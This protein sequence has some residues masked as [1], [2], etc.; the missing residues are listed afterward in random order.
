MLLV[1][2]VGGLNFKR[3]GKCN[4]TSQSWLPQDSIILITWM[5]VDKTSRLTL[6]AQI[7]QWRETGEDG[8]HK[9]NYTCTHA[10]PGET[11]GDVGSPSKSS[12][13]FWDP[14]ASSTTY[15]NE[16]TS[17][18]LNSSSNSCFLPTFLMI[19]RYYIIA[20]AWNWATERP[21]AAGRT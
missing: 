11:L 17:A 9:S 4:G 12:S 1:Y 13:S 10:K 2:R 16:P 21:S 5:H 20:A 7:G 19:T 15:S 6:F 8:R 14:S 3:W 18:A